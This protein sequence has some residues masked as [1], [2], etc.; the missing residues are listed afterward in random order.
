MYGPES[1]SP[2]ARVAKIRHDFQFHAKKCGGI[3]QQIDG[4]LPAAQLAEM[5]QLAVYL[6][7]ELNAMCSRPAK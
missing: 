4:D 6:V 2:A 5:R 3:A 1:F 7:A